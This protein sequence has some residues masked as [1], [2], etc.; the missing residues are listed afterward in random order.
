V[1]PTSHIGRHT[2][3]IDL[4]SEMLKQSDTMKRLRA[5]HIEKDITPFMDEGEK[6]LR[7]KGVDTEIEKLV[8]E[9]DPADEIL[10][11]ADERD[12][13]TIMLARHIDTKKKDT[14]HGIIGKVV[15]KVHKQVV[16]IIGS[17]FLQEKGETVPKILIPVDESRYSMNSV[18]YS[19]CLAGMLIESMSGI[20]L[21]RVINM[22]KSEAGEDD[23]E[24]AQKI[25]DNVKAVFIQ[26]GISEEK[27][28]TIKRYGEPAEEIIKEMAVDDYNMIVLGRE[29]RSAIKDYM[30]GGVSTTV[31]QNCKKPTVAIVSSE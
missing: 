21:L 14:M 6:I 31:I 23:E 17:E 7:D 8:L 3:Y 9:G 30:L 25:L 12:F 4:R 26:N 22:D 27:I 28:T 24:E 11:I 29:R 1:L 20:T 15:H 19:A 13:T 18:E 10:S 16:Y 2:D 5:Q